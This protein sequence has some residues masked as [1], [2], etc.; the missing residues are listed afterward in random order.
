METVG[1]KATSAL[2]LPLTVLEGKVD[3]LKV[4]ELTRYAVDL[5]YGIGDQLSLWNIRL[6]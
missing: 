5:L 3:V 4:S 1:G 2:R 6:P